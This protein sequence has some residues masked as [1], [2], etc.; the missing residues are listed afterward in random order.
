MISFRSPIVAKSDSAEFGPATQVYVKELE[1]KHIN[2][3]L[4]HCRISKDQYSAMYIRQKSDNTSL[5]TRR[6]R[7]TLLGPRR[8]SSPPEAQGSARNGPADLG[9]DGSHYGC[10]ISST[11]TGRGP[12]SSAHPVLAHVGWRGVGY[13]R[14]EI[15]APE[16]ADA[17]H[18]GLALLGPRLNPCSI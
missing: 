2:R 6:S 15:P 3:A 16:M 13:V 7:H 1:T 14:R 12:T 8:A 18:H 5:D 17:E 9:K 11:W 10:S 4:T